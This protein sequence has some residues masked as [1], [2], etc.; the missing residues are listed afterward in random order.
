[1]APPLLSDHHRENTIDQPWTPYTFQTQPQQAQPQRKPELEHILEDLE[2]PMAYISRLSSTPTLSLTPSPTTPAHNRYSMPQNVYIPTPSTPTSGSL[3]NAT[4]L[5]SMS[6][7]SSMSGVCN[8]LESMNMLKSDSNTFFYNVDLSLSNQVP[9]FTSSRHSRRSSDEEQSHLLKGAGGVHDS[10]LSLSFSTSEELN[11]SGFSAEK[12]E[13]SQSMESTSSTSSRSKERLKA[14]IQT[15]ALLPL[16]PKGGSDS[17]SMSRSNSSQSMNRIESKD[18]QEKIALPK[19]TYQR[20][21]HDRVFCK[22]C[23][24]HPEG[25][26]GEHEFRRHEDRQHKKVVKKWICVTPVGQGHPRP[27]QPLSRCKACTQ[28]QKKYNAYYN[29]AAHLRRAHF[30]PKS[31]GKSKQSKMDDAA[32][33]GG[34]GGGDWPSMPELKAWM[35]E[36]EELASDYP[37]LTTAQQDAA[38]LD[39]EDEDFNSFNDSPN[40]LS[41]GGSFNPQYIPDASFNIYPSPTN[42][43]FAMQNMQCLDSQQSVDSIPASFDN[44]SFN[45]LPNGDLAF[46]DHNPSQTMFIPSQFDDQLLVGLDPVF[47][48]Y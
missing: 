6:R 17:Q 38:D 21:K 48:T 44:F 34:K 22:K 15:A 27:E 12:M 23:D 43:M 26:R 7:Q 40:T 29:A 18:G 42:D 25:F 3:T 32:K 5:T 31:K 47:S 33:R 24:D 41:M 36:V 46:A 45:Q 1:M 20:P 2:D 19:T 13:K 35:M 30:R 8:E 16:A 10:Q 39:D 4:T 14:Q 37:P 9:H 28:Q 11:S